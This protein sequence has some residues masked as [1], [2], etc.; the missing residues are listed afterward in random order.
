MVAW[1]KKVLR[2]IR[3]RMRAI[4][5]W[6]VPSRKRGANRGCK[7]KRRS[8]GGPI[9]APAQRLARREAR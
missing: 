9:H 6:V 2:A 1:R 5:I 7:G 8:E 4:M 3:V